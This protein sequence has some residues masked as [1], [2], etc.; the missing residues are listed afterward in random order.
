MIW[1][2]NP[3]APPFFPFP[4]FFFFL[5]FS[6]FFFF[7]LIFLSFFFFFKFFGRLKPHSCSS[8][9]RFGPALWPSSAAGKAYGLQT[10]EVK[11][12]NATCMVSM[13][14]SLWRLG[15]STVR[16]LDFG[17]DRPDLNRRE[18]VLC[19]LA[20]DF[21]LSVRLLVEILLGVGEKVD[22]WLVDSYG[23]R[24]ADTEPASASS[25][26]W[27]GRRWAQPQCTF[28][29]FN[30]KPQSSTVGW[31]FSD[32]SSPSFSASSIK[33]TRKW[34]CGWT[35][36]VR[37]TIAR[38]PIAISLSLSA[39]EKRPPLGITMKRLANLCRALSWSIVDLT[40]DSEVSWIDCGMSVI[41]QVA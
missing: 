37:I 19:S 13:V 24:T 35:R 7:S 3:P 21:V 11:P 25:A 2:E 29:V 14:R 27:S 38:K 6:F 8:F 34:S 41:C 30:D 18:C 15:L 22:R 17:T 36:S 9:M 5:F 26:A 20:G 16:C 32:V 10:S 4:L 31:T 12:T 40:L 33:T 28:S 1:G 39:K 23:C